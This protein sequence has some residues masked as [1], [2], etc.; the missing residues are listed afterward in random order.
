MI[1]SVDEPTGGAQYLPA[2][3]S[4]EPTRCPY[5]EA[6]KYKMDPSHHREL[7][8]VFKPVVEKI[9]SLS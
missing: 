2:S 9:A 1:K 5:E 3:A 4:R 8:G 6:N 7:M